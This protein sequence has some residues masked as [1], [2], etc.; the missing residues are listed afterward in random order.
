M[1]VSVPVAPVPK[2]SMTEAVSTKSCGTT[3]VVAS[4]DSSDTGLI[5]SII[6]YIM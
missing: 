1:A 2:R 5:S 6:M 3:Y 4:T